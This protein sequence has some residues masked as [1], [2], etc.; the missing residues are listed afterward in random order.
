M[1]G[2]IEFFCGISFNALFVTLGFR[3]VYFKEQ[4]CS[5]LVIHNVNIGGICKCDKTAN[6][7]YK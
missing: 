5:S 1:N 3:A 2:K 4:L 6:P 7:S